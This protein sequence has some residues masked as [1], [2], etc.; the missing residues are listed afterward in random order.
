[1]Q[2][3]NLLGVSS[4]E[5]AFVIPNLVPRLPAVSARKRLSREWR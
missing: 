1:V 2:A 5:G 4:G 3:L